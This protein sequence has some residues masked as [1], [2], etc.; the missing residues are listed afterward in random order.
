MRHVPHVYVPGAWDGELLALGPEATHHVTRVLRLEPGSAVSYTDG[1]G[2]IGTGV[3]TDDGVHRGEERR[4][5]ARVQR[6]TMAV[7]AP[8][9]PARQ[10]FIVEKL[11]ELGVDRLVWIETRHGEGR[12]P[13]HD[14]ALAWAIASLEQ[15][16]RTFLM[17]IDG[18][19][20][21]EQAAPESR[22]LVADVSGGSPDLDFGTD[23]ALFVGPEGGFG[24]DELSKRW[25]RV[26]ISDGILRVETAAIVGASAFLALRR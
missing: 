11:A 5:A 1:E 22:C 4:T 25:P 13:R 18:P 2:M 6:L 16:R 9:A 19:S 20:K 7:A 15:S 10:R 26:A 14:K 8:K 21:P 23:V 17:E 24:T 12:A 3:L